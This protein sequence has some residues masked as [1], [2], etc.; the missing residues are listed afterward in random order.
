MAAEDSVPGTSLYPVKE[1][2]EEA[3]L[4]LTAPRK[5]RW[6][7]MPALLKSGLRRLCG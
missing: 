5:K 6:R 1:L 2:R 7:C 4:W 3:T